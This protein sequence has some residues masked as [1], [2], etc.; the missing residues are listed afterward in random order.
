[1][2]EAF[3]NDHG[4]ENAEKAIAILS[5][6]LQNVNGTGVI[7][8]DRDEVRRRHLRADELLGSLKSA[9]LVGRAHRGHIE[10]ESQQ[11]AI[12]VAF[13]IGGFWSDLLV[14]QSLVYLQIF[15]AAF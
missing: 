13:V 12:F 11:A 2:S 5:E 7:T 9:Q 3:A 4:L 8:H 14:R 15:V 10:V 6:I 1:V